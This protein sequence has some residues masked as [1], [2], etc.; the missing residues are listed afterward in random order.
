MFC[1][2]RDG[3]RAGGHWCDGAGAW[4]DGLRDTL[5]E[6]SNVVPCTMNTRRTL[7]SKRLYD[8]ARQL[9]RLPGEMM[10]F[11]VVIFCKTSDNKEMNALGKRMNLYF[12]IV[13]SMYVLC[14]EK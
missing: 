5:E 2:R 14:Q 1:S 13:N 10:L 9:F 4:I 12:H 6:S 8:T 3:R 7:S 11:F